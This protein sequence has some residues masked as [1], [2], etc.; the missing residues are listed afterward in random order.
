MYKSTKAIHEPLTYRFSGD[1]IEVNGSTFTSSFQ[2]THIQK[3]RETGDFIV[4]QINQQLGLVIPKKAFASGSEL[5]VFKILCR[6]K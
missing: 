5:E 2:W 3:I 4:L 6:I 1:N